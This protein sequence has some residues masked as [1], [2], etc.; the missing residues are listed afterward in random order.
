MRPGERLEVG[1][2]RPQQITKN[3]QVRRKAEKRAAATENSKLELYLCP[4]RS[5]VPRLQSS[6][7][8]NSN[9][10]RRH[11]I[12]CVHLSMVRRSHAS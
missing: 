1:E 3:F 5:Y 8:L 4:S 12:L 11:A 6:K 2:V 9:A 7:A 10:P